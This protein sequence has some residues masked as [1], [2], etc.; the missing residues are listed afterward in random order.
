MEQERTALEG[1]FDRVSSL[2]SDIHKFRAKLP[3]VL[4][5]ETRRAWRYRRL[6]FFALVV[7]MSGATNIASDAAVSF[8]QGFACA[9]CFTTA[10]VDL[11]PAE[12]E[13]NRTRHMSRKSEEDLKKYQDLMRELRARINAEAGGRQ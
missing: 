4:E 8:W 9:L 13:L 1:E 2:V 6:M 10:L 5:L 11:I 3:E 12:L 7:L